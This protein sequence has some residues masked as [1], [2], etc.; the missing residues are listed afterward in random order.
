MR[1]LLLTTVS[2]ARYW[3]A[4]AISSFGTAFTT[5]AMP[6]LVVDQHVQ[7]S[8]TADR[9]LATEVGAAVHRVNTDGRMVNEVARDLVSLTRWLDS[10]DPAE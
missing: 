7:R 8:G 2:F 6:V 9:R 3:A 10:Q 1:V 5:V 4:A